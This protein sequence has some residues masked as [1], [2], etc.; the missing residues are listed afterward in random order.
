MGLTKRYLDET[1]SL[2]PGQQLIADEIEAQ[3][4]GNY[5]EAIRYA[6]KSLRMARA[7]E[8]RLTAIIKRKRLEI[9]RLT[10]PGP[11]PPDLPDGQEAIAERIYEAAR[12]MLEMM[13]K[14]GMR[15]DYDVTYNSLIEITRL[16]ENLIE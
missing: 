5:D 8:D 13:E 14:E 7:E 2:T 9:Q 6:A 11:Y 1:M 16:G 10:F 4:K 15:R 3:A 12:H